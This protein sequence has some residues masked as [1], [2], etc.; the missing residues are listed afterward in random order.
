MFTSAVLRLLLSS[1]LFSIA[2]TASAESSGL[3]AEKM[4]LI[5]DSI[6]PGQPL[7]TY[8]GSDE[9]YFYFRIQIDNRTGAKYEIVI[10]D[11]EN[12]TVLYNDQFQDLAFMKKIAVP[13]DITRMKWDVNVKAGKYGGHRNSYSVSTDVMLREDVYVT[14]L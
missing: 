1:T 2:L 13:R 9:E 14:R 11:R 7:V 10:R 8:V 4:L 12:G 5:Q 3:P 6:P